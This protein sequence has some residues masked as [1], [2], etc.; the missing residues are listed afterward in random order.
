MPTIHYRIRRG[1]IAVTAIL[2][3]SFLSLHYAAGSDLLCLRAESR[4]ELLFLC[5]KERSAS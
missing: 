1:T 4:H 5:R 2:I 3:S